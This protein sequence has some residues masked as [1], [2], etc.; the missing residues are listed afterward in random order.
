MH[1]FSQEGAM[2]IERRR[3]FDVSLA[4]LLSYEGILR[5]NSKT[6]E[7][8]PLPPPD[9]KVTRVGKRTIHAPNLAMARMHRCLR[10]ALLRGWKTVWR[11]Q[12]AIATAFWPRCS[13]LANIE[14][15]RGNRFFYGVD[16][17]RAYE[18]MPCTTLA[19]ILSSRVTAREKDGENGIREGVEV[20]QMF[21]EPHCFA[22]EG[23]LRFGAPTSPL[24]FNIY[25]DS[26]LDGALM[27]IAR[28]FVIT[29]TRY[30]DDI[31]VSSKTRIPEMAKRMI[32]ESVRDAGFE[33]NP[34]KSWSADL[35]AGHPACITGIRLLWNGWHQPAR[36]AL[37]QEFRKKLR[38]LLYQAVH[39]SSNAE[40]P[41]TASRAGV[42][43]GLH[44]TLQQLN[45]PAE[46]RLDR[47]IAQ[48]YSL[49]RLQEESW[50]LG[51][52]RRIKD[53]F[54]EDPF[55]D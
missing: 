9:F 38:W 5:Y 4:R 26:A 27:E 25:C 3:V 14:R 55:W 2:N 16:I 40:D 42:I 46:N 10:T 22:P 39:G 33:L 29:I 7:E 37:S 45:Q 49:F 35:F 8:R 11:R 21:L 17:A 23:G 15:H 28:R 44:G 31:I 6:G 52:G 53:P 12:E 43:H 51:A 47:E 24:L 50:Q 41:L 20:W 13:T 34:K 30:A 54:L 48:L 36:L 1:V 19:A 18:T 32:R